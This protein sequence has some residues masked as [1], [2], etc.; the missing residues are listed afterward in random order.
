MKHLILAIAIMLGLTLQVS[1]Q[2]PTKKEGKEKKEMKD[3]NEKKEMK[4]HVCAAACA[5][6]NHVYAH[7][8]KGHVCSDACKH[9][10]HDNEPKENHGQGKGSSDNHAKENKNN[11]DHVCTAACVNGTHVYAHGEKGHVCSKGCTTKT[12]KKG[13]K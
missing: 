11:K 10:D 6:G 1:A 8:E 5:N 12:N 9:E 2:G 3:K 4:E 7:G 13:K